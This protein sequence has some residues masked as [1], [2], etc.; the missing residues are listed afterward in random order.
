MLL[1]LKLSCF[2]CGIK[3]VYVE[4]ITVNYH[5]TVNQADSLAMINHQCSFSLLTV[6]SPTLGTGDTVGG[7][8]L[9]KTAIEGRDS[10]P[11]H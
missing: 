9:A 6:V 1:T 7:G 8:A 11:L 5:N 10:H 2:D 4:T 3:A